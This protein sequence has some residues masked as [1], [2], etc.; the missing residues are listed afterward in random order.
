MIVLPPGLLSGLLQAFH[1]RGRFFE[2]HGFTFRA[3]AAH[4]RLSAG[5]CFIASQNAEAKKI[6]GVGST[7]VQDRI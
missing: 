4:R 3:V 2:A 5:S 7:A 6:K 1:H